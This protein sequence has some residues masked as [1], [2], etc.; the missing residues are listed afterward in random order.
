MLETKNMQ[1]KINW[2]WKKNIYRPAHAHAGHETYQLLY[3]SC[4]HMQ[5]QMRLFYSAF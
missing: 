4:T 2:I 5:M 1:R 3:T